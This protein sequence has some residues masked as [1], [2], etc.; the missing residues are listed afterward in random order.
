MKK[1]YVAMSADLVHPG[2]LNIINE[3]RKL[4]EVILGLL[5]DEAI[6]SYKRLPALTYEQRKVIMENIKGVSEV[7]PQ[8]TLDYVPNLKKIKPDY[9]VHGDDWRTGVQRET[10]Q[11]V[12][13]TL[14]EWGGQLVEPQYTPN[15][16]STKLNN[17]LKEI[18]TTPG[19]R[20]KRLRRL[21]AVKDLVTIIEAHSG[22]SGLIVENTGVMV[23]QQLREFDGMWLSSLTDSTSKGKPDI[24]CVDFTSRLNTLNDI[25]EVT[26]KPIIYDGDSGGLAEHFEYMVRTLE[27]GGISAVIIEDKVGLKKNSLLGTEAKQTQDTIENFSNKIS[28]GKKAQVTDDFMIIARIESLILKAG[29]PDALERAKAYIAAGADGIM[30]HSNQKTPAEILEFCEMYNRFEQKVPLV[31]VPSTYSSITEPELKQAGIRIVIYANQLLR[32]AYPAMVKTAEAILTRQRSM[33]CESEGLCMPIKEIL[34]LI[35]GG[36]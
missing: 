12:I 17:G 4:G 26:T 31:V 13:D 25:L 32:S 29:M 36:I 21:L 5:T 35:P 27:R 11:R 8:T 9:V 16:S 7:V 15:I 3:A 2:H 6:A 23:N 24:G 14:K 34:R 33:E 30:I 18:G 1:V 19:V 22:L 10:R 28:R 20:L